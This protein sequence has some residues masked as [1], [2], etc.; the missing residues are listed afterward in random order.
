ML[1]EKQVLEPMEYKHTAHE[2]TSEGKEFITQLN[3]KDFQLHMLAQKMLGS[4]Y[5]VEK[6]PQFKKWKDTK[7]TEASMLKKPIQ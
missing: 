2:L 4:S 1:L 5:F 6:T 7:R 3:P